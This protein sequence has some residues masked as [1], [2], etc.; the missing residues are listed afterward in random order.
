MYFQH[1]VAD[2]V[3]VWGMGKLGITG[4]RGVNIAP[5]WSS[6]W[7]YPRL[8]WGGLWVFLFLLP[9]LQD[10][11]LIRGMIYSLGSTFVVL[12]I[13]FPFQAHKGVMGLELGMMTPLFAFIV[14][15]VWGICAAGWLR[16]ILP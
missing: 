9:Y 11:I 10:S 1:A 8:V 2:S 7:F 6:V 5:D 3:P 15:A 14:N 13:V 12:F 16:L 4:A